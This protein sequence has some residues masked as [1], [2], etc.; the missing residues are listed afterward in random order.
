M[1]IIHIIDFLAITTG[2]YKYLINFYE[3]S[4]SVHSI[5]AQY[6][7]NILF[8]YSIALFEEENKKNNDNTSSSITLPPFEERKSTQMLLKSIKYYPQSILL[9][10]RETNTN[11]N[12]GQW[13]DIINESIFNR[14]FISN[15]IEKLVELMCK[16]MK[17]VW[18][19]E[20]VYYFCY[21]IFTF[22][23]LIFLYSY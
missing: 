1:G 20:N 3:S 16:R 15:D 5:N 8:G 21:I 6:Y 23:F 19:S 2:N 17:D 22:F 12:S 9:I 13:K 14:P 4:L 10:L 18:K 11:T 7:P